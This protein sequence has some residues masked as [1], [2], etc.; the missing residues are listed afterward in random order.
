MT[1]TEDL[2][3]RCQVYE[4]LKIKADTKTFLAV[5]AEK[6]TYIS[7][8]W[9][10]TTS[11]LRVWQW[12]LDNNLPGRVGFIGDWLFRAEDLLRNEDVYAENPEDAGSECE[13]ETRGSTGEFGYWMTEVQ[14]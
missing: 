2:R 11:R 4:R 10:Y 14:Y 5:T 13:I 9:K 8:R 1:F 3:L 12:K 6:W 7:Q